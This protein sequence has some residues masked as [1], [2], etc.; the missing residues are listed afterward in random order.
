MALEIHRYDPVS[1]KKIV[2]NF[3]LDGEATQL[4]EN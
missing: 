3:I 1:I 4:D 2:Q